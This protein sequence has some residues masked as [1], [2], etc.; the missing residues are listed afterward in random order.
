MS[1]LSPPY[2]TRQ[3]TVRVYDPNT[4]E[5]PP[6]AETSLQED[7]YEILS[8]PPAFLW[9]YYAGKTLQQFSNELLQYAISLTQLRYSQFTCVGFDPTV[10]TFYFVNLIFDTL[11]QIPASSWLPLETRSVYDVWIGGMAKRGR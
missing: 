1:W 4:G 8:Y 3:N 2:Y 11:K 5:W 7:V 10:R 9:G 6:T